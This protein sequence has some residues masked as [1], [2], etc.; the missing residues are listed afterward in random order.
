VSY[1]IGLTAAVIRLDMVFGPESQHKFLLQLIGN[2]L[3]RFVG[4]HCLPG[5][6]AR[7]RCNSTTAHT[8][9]PT[10]VRVDL[11]YH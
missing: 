6:E 5:F 4:R 3:V 11:S 9:T 8:S 7:K 10:M 2:C 1:L